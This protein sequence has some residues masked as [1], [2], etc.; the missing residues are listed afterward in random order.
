MASFA[1]ATS[2]SSLTDTASGHSTVAETCSM[3]QSPTHRLPLSPPETSC[4]VSLAWTSNC[5]RTADAVVGTSSN[6]SPGVVSQCCPT[7]LG[8]RRDGRPL[9]LPNPHP[10]PAHAAG[11]GNRLSPKAVYAAKLPNGPSFPTSSPPTAQRCIR[12]API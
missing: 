12:V 1:S 7:P 3:S 10:N 8:T 5:V 4:C 6:C 2:A 11:D 9:I